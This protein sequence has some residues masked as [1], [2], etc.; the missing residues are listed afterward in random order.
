M[1]DLIYRLKNV[2]IRLISKSIATRPQ[3]NETASPV[4]TNHIA[5]DAVVGCVCV[6]VL[7]I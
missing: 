4:L 5:F 6:C 3:S 1:F 2:N 7:L